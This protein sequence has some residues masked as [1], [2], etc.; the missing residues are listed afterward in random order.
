MGICLA[1]L[2]KAHEQKSEPAEGEQALQPL[3][4]LSQ[5]NIYTNRRGKRKAILGPAG[6][7]L[8]AQPAGKKSCL[9]NHDIRMPKDIYIPGQF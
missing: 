3:L 4:H 8:R 2:V 1:E 6:R 9:E 7:A 5:I